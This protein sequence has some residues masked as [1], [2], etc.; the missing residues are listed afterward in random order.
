M[1]FIG[2]DLQKRTLS[3][4]VMVQEGAQRRVVACPSRKC[5]R[6]SRAE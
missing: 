4:C 5:H 3:V 6:P 1:F 2:V